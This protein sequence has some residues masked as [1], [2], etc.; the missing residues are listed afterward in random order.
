MKVIETPLKDLVRIEPR[1]FGDRRGCFLET[2]QHSRYRDA[3]LPDF[4]QDNHSYSAQG[5]LRG[6][7]FQIPQPQGKLIY[8]VRGEI[9]DVA[10]DLRRSSPTFG[11]WY[12]VTLNDVNRWQLF[13]PEGFAHGFC[14]LS[15][16]ADVTYKC[17][18]LYAPANEQCLQWNDPE[19]NIPWPVAN[20]ILSAKDQLGRPLSALNCFA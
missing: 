19:L 8:V 18:S 1:V 11:K 16:T 13:V 3:G 20:P 6:L 17:T 10:V 9:W 2:Y 4:V 5:I 15:E 14:V 12:G 7:H